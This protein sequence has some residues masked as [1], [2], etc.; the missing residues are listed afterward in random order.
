MNKPVPNSYQIEMAK[1]FMPYLAE[2]E[3]D[4]LDDV[5]AENDDAFE[6]WDNIATEEYMNQGGGV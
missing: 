6:W 3:K 1:R 2:I 4:G 5:L